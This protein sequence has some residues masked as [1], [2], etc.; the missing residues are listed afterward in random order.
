[1][2]VAGPHSVRSERD[3]L[4][5]RMRVGLHER[6][7]QLGAGVRLEA[8]GDHVPDA[9]WRRRARLPLGAGRVSRATTAA[10]AGRGH[11]PGHLL[12]CQRRPRP[13]ATPSTRR[14]PRQPRCPWPRLPRRRARAGSTA[15]THVPARM[16]ML[17]PPVPGARCRAAPR[18][19]SPRL[20]RSPCGSTLPSTTTRG[21]HRWTPRDNR[22][23]PGAPHRPG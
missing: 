1:M 3:A 8:V 6:P 10:Q 13:D 12:R 11:E 7:V 18:R 20:P 23:P 14:R 19:W 22:L 4:H 21:V 15:T 17:R 5:H 2:A 9:R 16:A